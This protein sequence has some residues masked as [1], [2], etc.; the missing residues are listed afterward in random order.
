MQ[1]DL[2]I[3]TRA[4][5]SMEFN[6]QDDPR[7]Y[8]RELSWI[9]FNG[10]VLQE[11]QSPSVPLGDRL[12]FLAIFSANLDEFFRVRVAALRSLLLIKKKKRKKLVGMRPR[13]LLRRIAEEVTGQQEVFG[14]VFREELLPELRGCGVDL[15]DGSSLSADCASAVA[16]YFEAEVRQ[17]VTVQELEAG[18]GTPFVED[19]TCYL[20]VETLA[21]QG[22]AE[23]SLALVWIPSPPLPRFF[24]VPATPGC[25]SVM[26]LD[27]VLRHNLGSLFPGREIL[28][29]WAIKVSRDA[30]LYLEDELGVDLKEAIRKSL[31]KRQTG[32][33][34]R[35]L[36]DLSAPTSI[37]T[38]VQRA[39]ALSDE[40]LIEG[41]RYHNLHDLAGFPLPE[42]PDLRYAPMP[43]LAHPE[44]EGASSLLG[45]IAQKDQLLRFPYQ[46]YGYVIRFLREAA[47][48]PDVEE[49]W[50]SLYRV[51]SDSAV[52]EV[53]IQA[54]TLGKRVTAFVEFQA[55]FDEQS[56]LQW[57]D[58]MEA[59]GV[60][61]L[62]SKPGIKV[63]AK[64]AL[65]RR[66]EAGELRDYA[67][68]AT[69]NFNEK[70]ARIYADHGL[71]T[72]DT[73]L[74]TEVH[75]VFRI[76]A[77][78]DVEPH[79]EHLL[80]APFTLRTRLNDLIDTERRAALAGA[81]SGITAK[82]NSFQDRAMIERV[83]AAAQAGVPI[84]MVVRG[85]CCARP[86]VP[87]LSE[88]L[89]VRSIVDRF[90]EHSRIY[91]FHAAGRDVVYLASAD[92][93]SRNLNRRIEVAFPIFDEDIRGELLAELALQLNDDTKSRVIDADH[94][95]AFISE[96]NG[97]PVRAQYVMYERLQ[98]LCEE[99]FK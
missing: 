57:A 90:L 40:D 26:F 31:E 36:Y 82:L 16:D 38:R 37:V 30:D 97:T 58:R 70:T 33:P 24:R 5:D 94:S 86:G 2:T 49:I 69:G 14:R 12:L 99:A 21:E 15:L 84:R 74:T 83:Y 78:E 91:N 11:A 87:G 92:W 8:D 17:H 45:V 53:L 81:P 6:D 18:Q 54:A 72:A 48:D 79:F 68:L 63:H 28:G 89:E 51:A 73:R 44:L 85:I 76:L 47:E 27:D 59:A 65:V 61:T 88:C 75:R 71:L 62:H 43:P 52:A 35:F 56:N 39:L 93:M 10:R 95:N 19:H 67:Y 98:R 22:A 3:F 20:V 80:V 42:E 23:S 7:F 64:I 77:G 1:G 34:V 25:T 66:R 60:R 32:M 13:R 50:I 96:N 4:A 41:G 9:A 55:R 29:S 46:S